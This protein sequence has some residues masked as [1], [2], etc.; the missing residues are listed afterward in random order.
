MNY[1]AVGLIIATV[2]ASLAQTAPELVNTPEFIERGEHFRIWQTITKSMV[3]NGDIQ[4][5]NQSGY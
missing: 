4:W 3:E 2:T 5:Q 1:C